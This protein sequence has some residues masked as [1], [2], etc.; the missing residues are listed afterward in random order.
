MNQGFSAWKVGAPYYLPPLALGLILAAPPWTPWVRIL[1]LVLMVAGLYVL[2]FFRDPPRRAPEDALVLAAPADGKVAAVEELEETPH[3][4]G[5]CAR[6]SIFL[7]IFNVHVNRAPAAAVVEDIAYKPGLFLNAMNPQSGE[8]NEANT[9]R[10]R[11][12]HGPVTVRQISGLIARRIVC[13]VELG[14]SLEKGAKIGMIKFGS[15]TELYLP[16]GTEI[17]VETGAKVAGGATAVA[18]FRR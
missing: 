5:P 6:I 9:I 12:E 18:R 4:E 14:D 13:A 3:Y 10:M 1:G 8:V 15:R 16:P 2:Y 7:S 11:T 17:L